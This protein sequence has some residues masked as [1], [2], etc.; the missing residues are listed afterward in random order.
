MALLLKGG[1]ERRYLC[2]LLESGTWIILKTKGMIAK[3]NIPKYSAYRAFLNGLVSNF[4]LL[5]ELRYVHK[6]DGSEDF[7]MNPG[8]SNFQM[9]E[10]GD[11]LA[12][13]KNGEMS[14]TLWHSLNAF[15]S[16]TRTRRL[17]YYRRQ[18]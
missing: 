18:K 3:E 12:K 5:N 9:V 11:L 7:K 8:Y 10:K 2:A 16:K 14:T 4:P 1:F 17:L 15:I 13:D 6:I